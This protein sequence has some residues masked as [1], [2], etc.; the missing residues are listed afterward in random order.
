M[1]SKAQT[2]AVKS[3]L[4]IHSVLSPAKTT[5]VY[6]SYWRFASIRQ[7][8]FFNRLEEKPYPWTSDPIINKYKFTNVYRAADR[9]SQYLI[10]HVIYNENLPDSPKEVLFRILLFKLFNKIETWE[11]LNLKIGTITFEDYDFDLYDSILTAAI[12]SGRRIYSAAYIM[13]SGKSYFGFVRKHTNHLKLIE[14]ILKKQTHEKLMFAKS[15]QQ[16]FEII[17]NFPSLGDF[18]A[19][20]LLID[21]NYSPII[22]FSESEFV[23]PGPGA[24]G[25]ISKCFSD[26]AGL[27]NVEIIKLMTD[28]QEKEFERLGLSFKSLW[29]RRLQLIDCQNLFCEVDK[30]ARVK[31]P[32]I[33]GNSERLRIKQVFK[34]SSKPINFWF[35]PKWGIN[36]N[37]QPLK[38]NSI[39]EGLWSNSGESN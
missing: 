31:H 13:P 39:S 14:L 28:R 21:L 26:S 22:N 3:A 12:A 33:K 2:S 8:V 24:K 10:K 11:L 19:Y 23:V 1:T 4:T 5:E 9:V 27:S 16:A 18:L 32:Q 35:P 20:Q 17:K 15:M 36:K 6:D 37:I 38:S 7:E 30:Y 34:A 29:G 25:G